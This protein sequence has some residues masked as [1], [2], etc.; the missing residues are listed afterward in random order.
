MLDHLRSGLTPNISRIANEGE[1]A[2]MEPVFPAV[3]CTVQASI[4]SGKYPNQHAHTERCF[5]KSLRCF[6][7]VHSYFGG[8]V[9]IQELES[10]KTIPAYSRVC[11]VDNDIACLQ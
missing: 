8:R 5:T 3:T 11:G 7:A 9:G 2:K 6:A 10:K 1:S 4:L